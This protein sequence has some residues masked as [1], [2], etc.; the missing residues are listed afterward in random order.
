M[1]IGIGFTDGTLQV[2]DAITLDDVCPSFHYSR[3]AVTHVSFSHDSA[4]MATAVS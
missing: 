3:D 1:N 4:F 2:V